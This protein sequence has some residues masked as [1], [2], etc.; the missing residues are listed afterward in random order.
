MTAGVPCPALTASFHI[1]SVAEGIGYDVIS[2]IAVVA[3]LWF[4]DGIFLKL[5]LAFRW[6]YSFLTRTRF[7]LLWI[8]DDQ[9]HAGKL[10]TKLKDQEDGRL[11][12]H[13]V[14]RPRTLLFYPKS[15]KRTAA[16]ILLDTDVSKLADEP[17]V[18]RKIELRLQ[19][20]VED[21]GGLIGGHD[22]IYRRAR[23]EVLQSVFGCKTV[24][25]RGYKDGLVPYR[26]NSAQAGHP[27]AAG[28]SES[29]KLSDGEI[30]WGKWD[31][32]VVIVFTT[33]DKYKRPLV[34]CRQH[35]SGRVVWLNSGDRGDSLCASIA[36]PEDRFVLLLRNALRWVQGPA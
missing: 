36:K 23:N 33:D 8:D 11:R 25:F 35:S 18:A 20:F 31:S 26:L 16:A 32:D 6:T 24:E 27:L 34:T 3:L 5:R 19:A 30:C 15:P 2:G 12:F 9:G 4:R 7:V 13:V 17:K 22:L 10:I 29:Y 28:L 21:G 14:K 1:I